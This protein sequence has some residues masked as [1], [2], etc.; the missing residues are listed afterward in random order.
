VGCRE[1]QRRCHLLFF[2]SKMRLKFDERNVI[3]FFFVEDN[4]DKV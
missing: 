4:P 3:E 2:A 1:S